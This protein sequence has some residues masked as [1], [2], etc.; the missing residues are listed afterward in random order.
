MGKPQH[1]LSRSS[2]LTRAPAELRVPL[3]VSTV[4]SVLPRQRPPLLACTVHPERHGV[5]ACPPS[6][7]GWVAA[8]HA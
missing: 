6:R 5:H 4:Q 8:E 1:A 3:I 7:R 2:L